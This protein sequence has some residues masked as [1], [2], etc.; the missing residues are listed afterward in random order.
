VLQ[1]QDGQQRKSK[2]SEL[3]KSKNGIAPSSGARSVEGKTNDFDE[4]LK[5]SNKKSEEVKTLPVESDNDDHA[6]AVSAQ[7][8][9]DI[10]V[11]SN[12][13]EEAIA[14]GREA[15]N[16]RAVGSKKS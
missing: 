3:R 2:M 12:S 1:T 5:F 15:I 13:R 6:K 10:L 11:V 9:G 8:N 7:N 4:T 16:K 14:T